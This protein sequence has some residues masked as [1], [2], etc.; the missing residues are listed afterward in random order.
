MKLGIYVAVIVIFLIVRLVMRLAKTNST[1]PVFKSNPPFNNPSM[2]QP[3][4]YVPSSQQQPK[5]DFSNL[6]DQS[7]NPY[8][9]KPNPFA[10]P[11]APSFNDPF[12]EQQSSF[13]TMTNR[14]TNS[15]MGTGSQNYYCMYCGK[16]FQSI[17]AL[18]MDTCFKHPKSDKGLQKHVLYNGAGKPNIGF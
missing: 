3:P 18:K 1:P 12:D 14:N 5:D 16:K 17:A 7:N 11:S 6:F 10:N 2:R 9:Q 15:N 13:S 8:E 4:P